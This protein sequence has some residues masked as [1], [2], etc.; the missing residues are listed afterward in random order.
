MAPQLSLFG[1]T[2][3][4]YSLCAAIAAIVCAAAVF[5][6]LR[7]I[8][9]KKS[10]VLLLL[11]SMCAAFLIGARL[12][13]VAVNPSAYGTNR[14][15]YTPRMVGLSLYGGLL[16]AFL[17]LWIASRLMRLRL[18][19]LLDA[20]TY[21]FALAFC[22]ARIGCFLNGCCGGVST[23][24]PWGVVFPSGKDAIPGSLI[25]IRN[26]VHPTQLYE[27][28][29]A[30]V[31]ILLCSLLLK[32]R[33]APPGR[34]AFLYGIWFCAMRLAVLPLRALPYSAAVKTI[35]YPAIYLLLIALG[36]FLLI[37]TAGKRSSPN[38]GVK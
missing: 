8:G 6:P 3:K 16:G 29:L 21:P 28:L 26:A 15:W 1:L 14:P 35:L 34:R 9:I 5:R 10:G 13:N 20:F 30:L 23:K 33:N 31:G 32:K 11:L 7:R 36:V 19:P 24:L 17:V 18:L 27:L 22:I 12:W 2:V 38:D 4:S 25:A 37:R